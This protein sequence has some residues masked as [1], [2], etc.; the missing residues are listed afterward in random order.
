MNRCCAVVLTFPLIRELG[1]PVILSGQG[2]RIGV[3]DT[4]VRS[5]FMA[6]FGLAPGLRLWRRLA[7]QLFFKTGLFDMALFSIEKRQPD[8]RSKVPRPKPASSRHVA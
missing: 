5:P 6:L 2:A 3:R 1:V 4:V 8:M 7:G